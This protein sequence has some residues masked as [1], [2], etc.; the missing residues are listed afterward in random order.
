[1]EHAMETINEMTAENFT[2]KNELE[3]LKEQIKD[4]KAR[5]EKL[6]FENLKLKNEILEAGL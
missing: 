1:M 2:L 6:K 4:Q 5:I 3:N